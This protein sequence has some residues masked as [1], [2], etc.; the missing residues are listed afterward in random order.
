MTEI[1]ETCLVN[2]DAI[3]EVLSG[4]N[5]NCCANSTV[6]P[7]GDLASRGPYQT[8]ISPACKVPR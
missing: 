6:L 2:A 1:V 8:V 7:E 5:R 4:V 3:S